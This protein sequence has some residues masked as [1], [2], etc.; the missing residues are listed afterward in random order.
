MAN[1]KHSSCGNLRLVTCAKCKGK[2][3]NEY[4]SR[5]KICGG[6]GKLCPKHGADHGN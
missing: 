6:S 5:C 1:C 2:G 3:V 4:G